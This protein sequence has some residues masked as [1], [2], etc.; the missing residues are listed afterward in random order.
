[1]GRKSKR[2]KI[3]KDCFPTFERDAC[4]QKSKDSTP[5]YLVRPPAID[6]FLFV[7]FD[8]LRS[9]R[10][11]MTKENFE[12]FDLLRENGKGLKKSIFLHE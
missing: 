7:G 4:L 9:K 1:M 2:H 12:K 11:S 10:S 8:I 6:Y 5:L 3:I